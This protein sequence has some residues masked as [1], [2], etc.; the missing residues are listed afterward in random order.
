[1]T[2]AIVS[3]SACSLPSVETLRAG[4]TVVPL[5]VVIDG[6]ERAETEL[7][8]GQIGAA[9]RSGVAVTTSQ[10]APEEFAAAYASVAAAGASEIVSIHLSAALS[11]THA[12]ACRAAEH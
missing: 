8:D 4:V 5:R 7:M 3:D 9:L 11:G 6:R 10:P 2:V 12:V 1:M